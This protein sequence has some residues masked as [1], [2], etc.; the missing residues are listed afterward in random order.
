MR[1][2]ATLS[3]QKSF[4][5]AEINMKI[6]DHLNIKNNLKSETL[7]TYSETSPYKTVLLY[8][9]YQYIDVTI[10]FLF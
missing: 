1:K 9:L 8:P 2:I 3:P 10:H 5:R 6:C 7:V 4:F